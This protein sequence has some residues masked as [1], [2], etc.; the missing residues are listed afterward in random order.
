MLRDLARRMYLEENRNNLQ[1]ISEIFRQNFS[2][3]ILSKVVHH[4]VKNDRHRIVAVDGV[5]RASDIKYLQTLPNFKLIYIEADLE[6][7]FARTKARY[8]NSDD[9]TKTFAEFKKDQKKEAESQIKGLKPKANCVVNNNGS[10]KELYVQID[11]L[12]TEIKK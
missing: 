5:R 11:K 6:T 8:E 4:D 7:R 10:L 9:A 1:K 12:I 3:D 2:E